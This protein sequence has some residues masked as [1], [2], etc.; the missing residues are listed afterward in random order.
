MIIFNHNLL[1]QDEPGLE[2]GK[3]KNDTETI[4]VVQEPASRLSEN[5]VP[6]SD[7]VEMS[8][9]QARYHSRL[10]FEKADKDFSWALE[11]KGV[12]S[13]VWDAT[14]RKIF[15]LKEDEYTPERLRFWVLHTFF[16]L[17]LEL[18]R[19]YRLLHVGSVMIEG[20]AVLFSALSFGGKST[21]TDYFIQQ[22][23]TLLS[24]DCLAIGKRHDGYYAI[25]S[26]P[27]HRPFRE[28]ET[29]GY[30]TDNFSPEPK[31]LH[32]VFL[33]KKSAPDAAVMI[34]ELKGIEKFKAFH[35][36]SFINFNFMKEECFNF[37]MQMG[38]YVTVYQVIV[39]WDLGRLGE[40]H[41]VIVS[42]L[43][44]PGDNHIFSHPI[45]CTGIHG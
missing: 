38:Q 18:Q 30:Y 21:M 2:V 29:L 9:R 11:V 10:P 8:G 31:P 22:G 14:E 45:P 44:A 13:L 43:Q 5:F 17:V 33:L 25:P 12:L 3:F 40:I 24:D 16:P 19:T 34:T 27:F 15:Y 28:T 6:K 37:Y 32:A 1:F 41:E 4:P 26:Y 7:W 35:Y 39:P 20:K 23:H 36:S 42:H